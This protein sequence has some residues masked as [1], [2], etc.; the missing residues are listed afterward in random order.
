MRYLKKFENV[1]EY[2][3]YLNGD[4]I[5]LPRVSLIVNSDKWPHEN[6]P[7]SDKYQNNGPKW[8]D[9]SIV[10]LRFAEYASE[11]LFFR[12]QTYGNIEYTAEIVNDAIVLQSKN[13]ATGQLTDDL[14]LTLDPKDPSAIS[15][16]LN[17]NFGETP[18]YKDGRFAQ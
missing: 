11:T 8:V 17:I 18:W 14:N 16:I 3:R 12:N 7:S 2:A 4:D 9:F 13:V 5:W 10:G 6:P 1:E 15:Q